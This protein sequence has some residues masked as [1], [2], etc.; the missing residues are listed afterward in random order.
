MVAG[1]YLWDWAAGLLQAGEALRVGQGHEQSALGAVAGGLDKAARRVRQRV[2]RAAGV[3]G[4][5]G[6]RAAGA[7]RQREDVRHLALRFL[8]RLRQLDPACGLPVI[9]A[10]LRVCTCSC[11]V[12]GLRRGGSTTGATRP[13]GSRWCAGRVHAEH[14]LAASHITEVHD[15]AINVEHKAGCPSSRVLVVSEC[16][17]HGRICEEHVTRALSVW[18]Q[19]QGCLNVYMPDVL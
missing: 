15:T 10:L 6:R 9:S 2:E 19:W 3:R 17:A 11:A 7:Q 13:A 4:F 12:A 8:Q 14:L 16:L 18:K 1:G 5:R